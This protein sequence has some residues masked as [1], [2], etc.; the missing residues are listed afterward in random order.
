[1][2][3]NTA[4]KHKDFS[5]GINH[6]DKNGLNIGADFWRYQIGVNIIPANTKEKKPLKGV[7]WDIW[8]DN[9]IGDS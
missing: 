2:T 1:M 7:K 4:D 9:P 8:Q 3:G 6:A 5:I